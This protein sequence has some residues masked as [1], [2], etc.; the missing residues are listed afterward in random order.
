MANKLK[1]AELKEKWLEY[2][3]KCDE[4][5]IEKVRYRELLIEVPK[6]VIYCLDSFCCFAGIAQ[7]DLDKWENDR[8]Y[9]PLVKQVKYAVFARK[10]E[11]LVN[12]EGSTSGLIFDLKC[13][14][15]L[16]PKKGDGRDQDW[17]IT[18]NLD[19][20]TELPMSAAN[21]WERFATHEAAVQPE[22]EAKLAEPPVVQQPALPKERAGVYHIY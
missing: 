16:Y 10:L 20:P 7:G 9:A 4:L 2:C 19:G 18:L 14:Y 22:P 13:N 21:R 3:K 1:P 11:A 17:D 8:H 6:R 15:G 5:F 12:G